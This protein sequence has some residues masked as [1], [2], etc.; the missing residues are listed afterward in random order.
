M[1][2]PRV[3]TYTM[4]DSARSANNLIDC[5]LDEEGS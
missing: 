3:L 2:R 5:A 1:T 4:G